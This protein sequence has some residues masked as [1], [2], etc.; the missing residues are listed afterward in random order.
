MAAAVPHPHHHQLPQGHLAK[1]F[2]KVDKTFN[3]AVRNDAPVMA[4]AD[5]QDPTQ[6]WV[7]D[8][9]YGE[10]TK[11]NFGSPA[12]ALINRATGKVLKHGKEK[13]HQ[14]HLVEYRPGMLDEDVLFTESQDFG[15]GFKT[16]RMAS[17]T[18]LNMTLFHD[19]EGKKSLFHHSSK[20][21]HEVKEGT[22]LVLDTWHE[23]DNQLWKIFTL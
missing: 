23:T 9:S 10:R 7:K 17:D 12:F 4:P 11:D 5:S 20:S 16:V 3:L 18:L 21:A 14:L 1:I 2:C 13:G 15:E 8:M 6:L 19:K 22:P